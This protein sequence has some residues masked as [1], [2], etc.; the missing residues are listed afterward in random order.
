MIDYNSYTYA[1][2]DSFTNVVNEIPTHKVQDEGK[3]IIHGRLWQVIYDLSLRHPE[4]QFV[5]EDSWWNHTMAAFD[6]KRFRIYEGHDEIGTVRIE[7]WNNERFEIRNSRIANAMS[8][9]NHKTTTD[10]KKVVKIVEQFFKSKTLPE[11]VHEA[12]NTTSSAVSNRAWAAG[13]EFNAVMEKLAPALAAY[14]T[15]NMH[16]IRP[17]LEAYGAS[18]AALDALIEKNEERKLT[19]YIQNVRNQS[20]GVLVMLHGD[21]Y[22]LLDDRAGEEP[23]VV[24]A[25]QLNDDMR[26][27]MGILKV[28]EDNDVIESVGMRINPTTFYVVR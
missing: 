6:V 13:R 18:S 26:G 28:V 16:T 2:I 12:K 25:S 8:K 17:T 4:W 24:S 22:V 27:K 19:G 11:R 9:R 23:Q 10:P 14:V 15:L 21:K 1:K 20:A 7:T 3:S 5:G